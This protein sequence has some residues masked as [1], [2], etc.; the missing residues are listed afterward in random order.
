MLLVDAFSREGELDALSCQQLDGDHV[1]ACDLK[2]CCWSS[3]LVGPIYC[4]QS[5]TVD[6]GM[7]LPLV[8]DTSMLIIDSIAGHDD[9]AHAV[10]DTGL[11]ID[12]EDGAFEKDGGDERGSAGEGEDAVVD[13]CCCYPRWLAVT[14]N[15][16]SACHRHRAGRLGLFDRVLV[17]GGFAGDEGYVA[18]AAGTARVTSKLSGTRRIWKGLSSPSCCQVPI[19]GLSLPGKVARWQPWLPSLVEPMKHRTLVLWRCTVVGVP[20]VYIM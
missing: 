14:T 1:R 13:A 9:G 11:M 18:A 17:G 7:S 2:G 16:R 15:L 3:I 20:A 19:V 6:G 10:V 4:L 12:G 5:N 8:V